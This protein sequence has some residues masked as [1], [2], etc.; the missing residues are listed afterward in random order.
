LL[1]WSKG[2]EKEISEFLGERGNFRIL[3]GLG[4]NG[5]RGGGIFCENFYSPLF[6]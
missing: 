6:K 1:W 4:R 5:E 2:G 3:S